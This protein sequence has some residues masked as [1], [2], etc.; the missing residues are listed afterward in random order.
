ME[1]GTFD[2]SGLHQTSGSLVLWKSSMKEIHLKDDDKSN[3]LDMLSKQSEKHYL[4]CFDNRKEKELPSNVI[5]VED[6]VVSLPP[7][8][9]LFI[10]QNHR[11]ENILEEAAE[12]QL[13]DA[14]ENEDL[15][16]ET[17]EVEDAYVEEEDRNETRGAEE[18]L[19]N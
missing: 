14:D 11:E 16:T 13:Q 18:E 2:R 5:K 19:Q 9:P 6:M 4:V 15:P 17:L 3:G 10:A 8:M 1:A 12:A 7:D